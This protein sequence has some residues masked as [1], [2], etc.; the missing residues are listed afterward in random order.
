[1][2]K[3]QC[4]CKING[5]AHA[6]LPRKKALIPLQKRGSYTYYLIADFPLILNY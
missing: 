1:L 3:R 6:F 2:Y 4:L 5:Q